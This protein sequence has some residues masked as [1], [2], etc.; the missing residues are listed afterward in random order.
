VKVNKV[1]GYIGA[2]L[3]DI[4]LNKCDDRTFDDVQ[5]ALWDHG[6]IFFRDQD[7]TIEQYINFGK[8]WGEL[9][10]N[11][12]PA[13]GK[14]DNENYP[15]V[16]EIRKNPDEVSNIG[17]EWHADQSY[18]PDPC[19]GTI[20]YARDVPAYGGDT[21]YA[22]TTTAYE[23]LSDEMKKEIEGLE[24]LHS[25]SFLL[26][27]VALRTG[28]P[29]GRFAAAMKRA[30]NTE[31]AHPVVA[32]HPETGR[33]SLYISPAY[34]SNFVG[35]SREE[36]APLL[37]KLYK[38]VLRPEFNCR[39]RWKNNSLAIWDNRQVWHYASNDYQG[40]L[41][42]LHRLVVKDNLQVAARAAG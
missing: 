22:N 12:S 23:L 35:M 2:E 39:M 17:D 34:T 28:D 1:G 9:F 20:L 16:E 31:T 6:V 30:T 15:E 40:H 37:D 38:H 10:V 19:M 27:Q 5:Q 41:R 21:C 32:T 29:D 11:N 4:D 14:V 7:F 25:Q 18:R 13:I 33:K 24:A 26:E 8:R 42:I 36:S 3:T